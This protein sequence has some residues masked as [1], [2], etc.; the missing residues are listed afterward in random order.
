LLNELLAAEATSTSAADLALPWREALRHNSSRSAAAVLLSDAITCRYRP[1]GCRAGYARKR[2][3]PRRPPVPRRLRRPRRGAADDVD[4]V[5][6][7]EFSAWA[8]CC[9]HTM[10]SRVTELPPGQVVTM[11]FPDAGGRKQSA[12]LSLAT[13]WR[14]PDEIRDRRRW[15][16]WRAFAAPGAMHRAL[17]RGADRVQLSGGLTRGCCSR[18]CSQPSSPP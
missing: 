11:P 7:A 4:P 13:Y 15:A 16:A 9:P 12:E 17:S 2:S 8:P 6:I 1:H 3:E 10:Y 5:S 18:S 14:P